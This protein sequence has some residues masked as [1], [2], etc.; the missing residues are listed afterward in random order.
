MQITGENA[1]TGKVFQAEATKIN[2]DFL[3][4]FSDLKITDT[5]IKKLIDN[6]NV[7]ADIKSAIYS[8]SKITINVGNYILKVGRKII[9]LICFVF[10]EFPNTSFGVIFGAIAG[11]LISTIPVLGFVLGPFFTPIAIGLSLVVGF[12]EDIKDKALLRK[13]AEINAKFSPLNA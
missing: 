13:I 10:K 3:E 7:S 9:D 1:K 11:F 12:Q 2:A 4:S 8:F 5:S 6:L